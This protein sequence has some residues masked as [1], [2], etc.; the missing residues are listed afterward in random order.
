LTQTGQAGAPKPGMLAAIVAR[1]ARSWTAGVGL[2]VAVLMVV[3]FE[4]GLLTS[5]WMPDVYVWPFLL[6]LVSAASVGSGEPRHLPLLA[7]AV[8]LLVHGHISFVVIAGTIALLGVMG[9]VVSHL[10]AG[11]PGPGART[12]GATGAVVAL[13]ALP[14]VLNLVLHWP[15]QFEKYWRYSRSSPGRNHGLA[16]SARFVRDYW[17][18]GAS[19]T[20]LPLVLAALTVIAAVFVADRSAR[21]FL[22]AAVGA[23]VAAT[24]ATIFYAWRGVD[25]L[26]WRYV[27]FF[28]YATEAVLYGTLIAAVILLA[29]RV[30]AGRGTRTGRSLSIGAGAVLVVVGLV[31]AAQPGLSTPR[32]V[33]WPPAAYAT[34]PGSRRLV[35]FHVGP[36]AWPQSAA[37]LEYTRRQGR[38]ACVDDAKLAVL[39]T[40]ALICTPRELAVADGRVVVQL[41]GSVPVGRLLYADGSLV[42]SLSPR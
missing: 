41:P 25:D 5:S 6:L 10:R 17:G 15:G 4:S 12:L 26:E 13:F 21:R 29:T 3:T 11:T 22:L 28:Y 32:G 23:V 20:A 42:V 38:P 24:G 19:A 40:D 31:L 33:T 9:L 36:D 30:S 16:D 37:L 27:A 34:I 35:A 18:H 39:F 14:I 8:G 1:R 7:L 2:A